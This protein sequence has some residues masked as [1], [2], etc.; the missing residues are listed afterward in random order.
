MCAFQNESK[1]LGSLVRLCSLL[2]LNV[3]CSSLDTRFFSFSL[4]FC[5]SSIRPSWVPLCN[6][7]RSHLLS[8]SMW[9]GQPIMNSVGIRSA[10]AYQSKT[11]SEA[12]TCVLSA[13]ISLYYNI[14]HLLAVSMRCPDACLLIN[15]VSPEARYP[16][17]CANALS[18]WCPE[19]AD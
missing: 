10:A 14:F 4:S 7:P 17:F 2:M 16:F 15:A 19:A 12:V 9:A 13:Q 11:V 1:H 6:V 18:F 5:Q 8:Y 3:D